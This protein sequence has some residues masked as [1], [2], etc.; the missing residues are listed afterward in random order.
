M[1]Y[2]TP[3]TSLDWQLLLQPAV[4]ICEAGRLFGFMI[5]NHS[6]KLNLKKTELTWMRKRQASEFFLP[7]NASTLLQPCCDLCHH[8][9]M[10]TRKTYPLLPKKFWTGREA[11]GK[12]ILV[13][14]GGTQKA[15][16]S[17]IVRVRINSHMQDAGI[18]MQNL[19]PTQSEEQQHLLWSAGD[20]TF[21]TVLSEILW[22][23][24]L[25]FSRVFLETCTTWKFQLFVLQNPT[26]LHVNVDLLPNK[27]EKL[28]IQLL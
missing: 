1:L 21:A 5:H 14:A 17:N 20:V 19:E 6:V 7:G 16:S 11:G 2:E 10:W 25:H 4:S 9:W 12:F 22:V 23:R 3:V 26:L 15:V 8:R 13:T 27:K 28:Q 18:G 24:G